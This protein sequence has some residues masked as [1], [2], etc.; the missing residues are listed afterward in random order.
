MPYK[1]NK[2]NKDCKIKWI[3]D[4]PEKRNKSI[5]LYQD[6]NRAKWINWHRETGRGKCNICGYDK[7]FA[8]IDQHHIDPKT[9]SFRPGTFL[10]KPFNDKNI[11]LLEE[12]LKKCI[13]I[14][15]NCH[16]EIH[17][18]RRYEQNGEVFDLR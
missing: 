9:K 3:K 15:S 13:S 16:R 11:K 12:E 7:C 4:N 18:T 5:R 2:K 1:D 17:N 8:A 14:C 10:Q 6:V